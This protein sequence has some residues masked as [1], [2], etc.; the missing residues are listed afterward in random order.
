M[1]VNVV[2][3]VNKEYRQNSFVVLVQI[4]GEHCGVLDKLD[5]NI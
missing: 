3:A 1:Q 4:S 5:S 2:G